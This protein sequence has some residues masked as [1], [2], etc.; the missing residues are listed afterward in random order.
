MGPKF[1]L[2]ETK[3]AKMH[4]SNPESEVLSKSLSINGL[5][6]SH[7][8]IL[9]ACLASDGVTESQLGVNILMNIRSKPPFKGIRKLSADAYKK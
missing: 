3:L 8:N 6:A 1:L 2:L 9:L 7:E 5:H 4:L